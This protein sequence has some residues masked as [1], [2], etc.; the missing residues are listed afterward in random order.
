MPFRQS[1]FRRVGCVRAGVLAATVLGAALASWAQQSGAGQNPP[2]A[3]SATTKPSASERKT[4]PAFL[5]TLAT[6]SIFFPDIAATSGPLSTAGKFKLFASD[7]ISL[8]VLAESA[9]SSSITQA[10]NSPEGWGQG[11]D[12]Y[13][14]RFG[15]SMAR[16]ASSEFFGTFVLASALRQDPRFFPQE[17]PTFG[18]SLKYSIQRLVVTRSDDGNDVANWSG[19]LGPLMAEGLANSYWPEQ[20]RT[21]GQTFE[22]YGYDLAGRIGTNMLRNYWPV[23]FKRLR[24]S[25]SGRQ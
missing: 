19:L 11:W 16:R 6:R 7:S 10:T 15:S 18:G 2:D 22:R 9:L 20:D 21:V 12:A 4:H 13:A 1:P 3:P 17:N 25:H 23:F 24:G 8:G 14:K 5:N